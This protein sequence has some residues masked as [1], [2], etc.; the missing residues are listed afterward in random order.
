[1]SENRF[2]EQSIGAVI[3]HRAPQ[4]FHKQFVLLKSPRGDWNF[5]KGHKEN[6]ETDHDTLKREIFEETGITNFNILSYLG[7][8]KYNIMK[9]G[10]P[11][12]KEVKFYYATTDYNQIVL[13][14][15]HI[16]YTWVYY[17]Q[18][19]KLLTYDQSKLILDKILKYGLLYD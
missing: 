7:K 6:L 19:R 4:S 15:E 3:S 17:E 14:N 13:S 12:Q 9:S 10:F 5:V 1:M 8:I 18:A 16:D 11:I 2:R